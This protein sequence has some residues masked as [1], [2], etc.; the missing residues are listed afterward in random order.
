[1]VAPRYSAETDL[2]DTNCTIKHVVDEN[3][4]F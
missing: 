3:K 2:S 1:M 4:Y